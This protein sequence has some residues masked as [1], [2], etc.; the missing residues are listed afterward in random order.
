MTLSVSTAVLAFAAPIPVAGSI[1]QSAPDLIETVQHRRGGTAHRGFLARGL[2]GGVG[3]RGA[4]TG[5]T[6]VATYAGLPPALG[7]CRYHIN[8]ERPQD[9]WNA[10]PR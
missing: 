1:S 6:T 4:A 8:P 3:A 5:F 9:F 2:R 10:C 7:P